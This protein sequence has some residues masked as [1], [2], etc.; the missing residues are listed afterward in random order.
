MV[1]Q[2]CLGISAESCFKAYLAR[3]WKAKT[4]AEQRMWQIEYITRSCRQEAGSTER[5]YS[6]QP[7]ALLLERIGGESYLVI[8]LFCIKMIP[9]NPDAVDIGLGQALKVILKIVC[10]AL[11][12]ETDNLFLT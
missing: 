8:R 9:I 10:I 4:P 2:K 6:L 1:I 12:I 11:K 7:E 5:C 3:Q